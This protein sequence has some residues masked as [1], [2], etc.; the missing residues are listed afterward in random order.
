MTRLVKKLADLED[1]SRVLKQRQEL[2]H[3]E[4]LNRIMREA[5]HA[6]RLSFAS[7]V[8]MAAQFFVR[9]PTGYYNMLVVDLNS[10][11]LLR[12]VEQLGRAV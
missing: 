9:P 1:R 5:L 10:L 6:Q 3:R 12:A 11:G 7:T 4:M 2:L 8:A